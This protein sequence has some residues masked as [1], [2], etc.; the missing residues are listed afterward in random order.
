MDIEKVAKNIEGSC[1]DLGVRQF[2]G[3]TLEDVPAAKILDPREGDFNEHVSMQASMMAYFG[4]LYKSAERELDDVKRS[5]EKWRNKK[6]LE[7][8]SKKTK[9]PPIKEIDAEIDSEN[10]SDVDL[11]EKRI[12]ECRAR[13]D[14]VG[15]FYDALKQKSHMLRIYANM[16]SDEIMN[17]ASISHPSS[18]LDDSKIAMR[19]KIRK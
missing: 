2:M 4:V 5:Y 12:M 15:I 8:S 7:V 3:D 10:E 9:K 1:D 16:N 18:N 14:D 11:W 6:F 17:S 13:V 19:K